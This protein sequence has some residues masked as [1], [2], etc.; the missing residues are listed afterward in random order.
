MFPMFLNMSFSYKHLINLYNSSLKVTPS[1]SFSHRGKQNN[2]TT[3]KHQKATKM[4]TQK[5]MLQLRIHLRPNNAPN[6]VANNLSSLFPQ[7]RMM[8]QSSSVNSQEL[9]P[10]DNSANNLSNSDQIT[11]PSSANPQCSNLSEAE[12]SPRKSRSGRVI[13]APERLNL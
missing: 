3:R 6:N 13:R 2:P 12:K 4:L 9:T 7:G 8:S 10:A 11:R 1:N 5:L